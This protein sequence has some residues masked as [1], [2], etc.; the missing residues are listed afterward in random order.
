MDVKVHIPLKSLLLYKGQ[1]DQCETHK[2][3]DLFDVVRWIYWRKKKS[4][5]LDGLF[6]MDLIFY[7]L[8]GFAFTNTFADK[9]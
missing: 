3:L 4:P 6:F 8:C 2:F 5:S 9:I 1:Q 7:I